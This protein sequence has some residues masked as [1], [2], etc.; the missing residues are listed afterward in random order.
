MDNTKKGTSFTEGNLFKKMNIYAIP[1]IL[2]GLLQLLFSAADL[3]VCGQFGSDNS[4][5]AISS[6]GPLIS[7]IINLFIGIAT[8]SNV[9]MSRAY[10]LRDQ[11]RGQKIVYT[12]M[13]LSII[14]GLIVSVFGFIFSK[15]LLVMQDTDE[16]LLDLSNDYLKIYF[17]GVFFMMIYNFGSSLLRAVGDTKR[18]FIFLTIAGVVNVLFNLIFVI[19]LKLDVTGV[20]ISTATS[21]AVSAILV[22][23]SLIKNK[24]FFHFNIKEMKMYA[25][26]AKQII[27]IGIPA[28]IQSVIFSISNVIIQA[29]INSL[30]PTVI[31]GNGAAMSIEGFIYT[32]MEQTC[33]TCIAFMSANYAIHNYKNIKKIFWY[34]YLMIIMY[35]VFFS[36]ITLLIPSQL[37]RIY[38]HD[39]AA[40]A[41]GVERLIILAAT[42][43]ICGFM[44]VTASALRG[45]NYQILPTVVTSVGICGTRLFF[46][47]VMFNNYEQFHN[48]KSISWSYPVSWIITVSL[49]LTFFMVLFHKLKM[50][51][52]RQELE[53]TQIN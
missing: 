43:A 28:G 24:S 50:A 35:D 7:L 17:I 3:V 41:V 44:D 1:L 39:E 48:L 16:T 20:A 29:S 9:L 15:E 31:N 37:L 49:N 2:S 27:W 30:G 53:R 6:T 21:Q 11:E 22:V 46:I 42:Y 5:G 47:Y 40:I 36:G 52:I 19:A 26:D 51:W 23:I 18:P 45:I 38:I 13:Y 10:G 4:V 33:F 34:S 8:G 25:S 32:S 12:S 14:I